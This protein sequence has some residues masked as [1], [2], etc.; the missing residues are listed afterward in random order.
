MDMPVPPSLPEI[1][2]VR[3]CRP[4]QERYAKRRLTWRFSGENPRRPFGQAPDDFFPMSSG[5]GRKTGGPGV[6]S[7]TLW[8]GIQA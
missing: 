8:P 7:R 4:L 5:A 3:Y 1:R 2:N 6:S